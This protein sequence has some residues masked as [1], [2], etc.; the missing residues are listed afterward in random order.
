MSSSKNSNKLQ[1]EER[2]STLFYKLRDLVT[3]TR[4]GYGEDIVVTLSR[5]LSCHIKILSILLIL[6]CKKL[7]PSLI[8]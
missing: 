1:S 8:I 6:Y 3:Q 5:Q 2:T 7:C 4:A